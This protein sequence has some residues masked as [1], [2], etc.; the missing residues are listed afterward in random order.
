MI[1]VQDLHLTYR[2]AG[3]TH[4]ALR[5]VGISLP[6]GGFLAL[7]GPSGCG[8]TTLLRCIAGLE[9]P[10]SG[11][12]S[13]ADTVVFDGAA[14]I[15][16]PAS[17]R[18]LGM[19]FQSYAIWPHMS[20]F[21]NAAFPLR[22]R[23]PGLRRREVEA[24]VRDVLDLV[25]LGHLADR[26]APMLSG[27]QQQRLA[28]ARAL[29]AQPS[30]LL[31]DEPLSNLD[32]RL[33]EEMRFE[34]RRITRRLGVTTV[35][36]THEQAEAL[37]MADE[38]VVM[39]DGQVLQSDSP[40]ALYA[41]PHS[42]FV[43][44]FVG[45]ANLMEGVLRRGADGALMVE[46]PLGLLSCSANGAAPGDVVRAVLRPEALRLVENPTQ[47]MAAATV[48]GSAFLG[49]V[50]EYELRLG[51]MVLRAKGDPRRVLPPGT[52]VGLLTEGACP[53]IATGA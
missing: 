46:T 13:I 18:D 1:T 39:R 42:A 52:T 4:Q 21:Q 47:G 8:K 45:R 22:Y 23:C 31:L 40:Q 16:L 14:G 49:E 50:V 51:D 26:P 53:V 33:R 28:L 34:L 38:V 35:F 36:V 30:V 12:I 6:R 43:A 19:V 3:R 17:R 37:S 10:D 15:A 41:A 7:L 11:R 32:A 20:V 44:D 27:G 25:Q 2:G 24:R 5:G 29:V 9:Q 48:A